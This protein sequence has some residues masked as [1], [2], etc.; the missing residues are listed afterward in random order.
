MEGG[1]SESAALASCQQQI[2]GHELPSFARLSRLRKSGCTL[3]CELPSSGPWDCNAGAVVDYFGSVLIVLLIC[4]TVLAIFLFRLFVIFFLRMWRVRQ[5]KKQQL[6]TEADDIADQWD[7]FGETHTSEEVT[8][9][10]SNETERETERRSGGEGR[11]DGGAYEMK[12]GGTAA[13]P[14]ESSAPTC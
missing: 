12:W 5:S 1:Q 3:K 6:Q 13:D 9:L 8:P 4:L 14:G 2:N 7:S 10:N 11:K